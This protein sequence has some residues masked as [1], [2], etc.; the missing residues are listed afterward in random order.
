MNVQAEITSLKDSIRELGKKIR[1]LRA[2][3]AVLTELP[4][5][6]MCGSVLDFDRLSHAET[7]KLIRKLGGKWQKDRNTNATP[8]Q[9][10]I[11]Y[12]STVEGMRVRIWGGEPPPSCRMVEIEEDVPE[13]IIPA[14]KVKTWKM[15]C[16]GAAE[17]VAVAVSRALTNNQPATDNP[18]S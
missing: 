3:E 16:T 1:W 5:G 11:D 6:S 18:T 10:K 8:G 15:I 7:I 2:H 9:T 14:H 4:A 12:T 13:K 17:P